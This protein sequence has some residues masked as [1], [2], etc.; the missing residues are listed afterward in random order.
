[1]IAF[2]V[3]RRAE[4]PSDLCGLEPA[5]PAGTHALKSASKQWDGDHSGARCHMRRR[6]LVSRHSFGRNPCGPGWCHTS[7]LL[8]AAFT[9]F[10]RWSQRSS[11]N[12]TPIGSW[13]SNERKRPAQLMAPLGPAAFEQ[14]RNVDEKIGAFHCSASGRLALAGPLGCY[15]SEQ[16]VQHNAPATAWRRIF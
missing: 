12:P 6:A 16:F 1:M 7:P 3:A 11:N 4:A 9:E 8:V 14:S 2:S 13:R 5:L 10:V 15:A